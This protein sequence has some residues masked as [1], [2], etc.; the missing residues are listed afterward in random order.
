[1]P[2]KPKRYYAVA[3]GKKPGIYRTWPEAESQVSGFPGAI[4]KGFV[5]LDQAQEWLSQQ[6]TIVHSS[7]GRYF[8][9]QQ[10]LSEEQ[11]AYNELAEIRQIRAQ[12]GREAA[13]KIREQMG[14]QDSSSPEAIE[15]PADEPSPQT[16]PTTATATSTRVPA[17]RPYNARSLP[18]AD[19]YTRRRLRY[20]DSDDDQ[21]A[22]DRRNTSPQRSIHERHN[23]GSRRSAS[24]ERSRSKRPR[25]P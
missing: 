20:D 25:V 23:H 2:R 6:A 1:M 8:R 13:R 18:D 7:N 17:S 10:G 12:H 11:V 22:R 21:D 14:I 15:W 19:L 5:E 9:D 4:H 16:E 24:P 3:K